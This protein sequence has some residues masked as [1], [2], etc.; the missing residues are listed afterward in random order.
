[1]QLSDLKQS[2]LAMDRDNAL[3]L[4][5]RI[6]SNRFSFRASTKPTKPT[7]KATSAIDKLISGMSDEERQ[8]LI[9]SLEAKL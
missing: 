7:K 6:Q 2:I 3:Q 4:I 9:D 1:M 5:E 8:L